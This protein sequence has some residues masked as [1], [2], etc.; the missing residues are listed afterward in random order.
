[1]KHRKLYHDTHLERGDF[2]YV[3]KEKGWAEIWNVSEDNGIFTSKGNYCRSEID[4][5][6]KVYRK[7][8]K[9]I[10]VHF[11][12]GFVF[13]GTVE[14]IELKFEASSKEVQPSTD[15]SEFY[16]AAM[17]EPN[18]EIDFWE[19]FEMSIKAI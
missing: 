18:N 17:D 7:T 15:R 6:L 8:M 13:V 12:T 4:K 1:M 9:Y 5:A 10:Y 11:K 19:V 3:G 2:I 14:D 16:F